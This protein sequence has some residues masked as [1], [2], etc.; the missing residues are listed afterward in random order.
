MT[1][2]QSKVTSKSPKY[3]YKLGMYVRLSPSDEIRAE[4]S[5]ISH[6]QRI[7]SHVD[8]KNSQ[9]PFWGEVVETYTDADYSGKDTNRPGFRKM[10]QD[11]RY[12]HINAVIVTELSRIS[13]DVKDFCNFWE[14]L[15]QHDATFISLKENFDTT[16]PIGEMM[17]IQAISFAQFERKTIVNRIK[18][19]ARA[20][21]ERGLSNGGVKVL[22]LDPH[23]HKKGHLI[24]NEKE[25]AIVRHITQ[26][27]LELGSLAKLRD[28]LN[29]NGYRTKSYVTKSGKKSG[30]SV[31]SRQTLLNLLTNV[32]LI[33]KIPV[34][35]INKEYDQT[36]LTPEHQYRL[37]D[38]VWPAI[39]DQANF[40]Q[41]QER[42]KINKRFQK[43]HKHTYRLSGLI[44]CSLCGRDLAGA[45][46]NGAKGKYYYYQH[47][48][49]FS[50]KGKHKE[51][52]P[53][54]RIPAVRLEEAIV[55]RIVELAKDRKLL[56]QLLEDAKKSSVEITKDLGSMIA[57]KTQELG[58]L[59]RM[60]DNLVTSLAE[61]PRG[62]KPGTI[63]SKV[64][65]LEKEKT[66]VEKSLDGLKKEK[67]R[68][69]G[70]VIDMEQAFNLF[71]IFN[72]DFPS[73]PAHEQRDIL[74]DVIKKVIVSQE[75]IKILYFG[76]GKEE[77]FPRGGADTP[78]TAGS[79]RSESPKADS[80]RSENC[81]MN[82]SG[83]R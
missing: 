13:R 82:R 53:L 20:R 6:P 17:V 24:I 21:A 50:T 44:E 32:K 49:N 37:V 68:K 79:D 66:N 4:G 71:K 77:T 45:S 56:E 46:A 65:K 22:G 54:E 80:G 78:E 42:L 70:G 9:E 27:F 75:N 3:K 57:S 51:R 10:L 62:V 63:L 83:V 30:G 74:R 43:R 60:I 41:I 36:E 33:G 52:C 58:R 23:K 69:G 81:T 39:I 26:K 15:K 12:G 40:D 14:L 2:K 55:D 11:L 72:R 48:R 73:R 7:R 34:N 18:D 47:S 28:Y 76:A 16:T 35:S 29:D 38:A 67:N 64:E 25:A 59:E 31:W 19:G 61:L 8:Y 1:K 5:L